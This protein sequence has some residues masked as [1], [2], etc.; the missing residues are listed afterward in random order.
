MRRTRIAALALA[1]LALPVTAGSGGGT[2]L[3]LTYAFEVPKLS[4][5]GLLAVLDPPEAPFEAL[6]ALIAAQVGADP[7]QVWLAGGLASFGSAAPVELSGPEG[8]GVRVRLCQGAFREVVVDELIP[9]AGA[10]LL[11][12]R[13]IGPR[14]LV[15]AVEERL[16]PD[17]FDI[18]AA[19]REQR[20]R[21]EEIPEGVDQISP[22]TLY[23]CEAGG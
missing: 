15:L 22:S 5:L 14:S 1:A 4:E 2:R 8:P 20:E 7:E 10:T 18:E 13:R 23:R 11:V 12:A 3:A 17:G 19:Q 9:V 21:F 16:V 6:P